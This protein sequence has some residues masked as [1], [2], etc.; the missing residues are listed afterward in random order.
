MFL[1]KFKDQ[2][3]S[4]HLN[5]YQRHEE[6]YRDTFN[7]LCEVLD[8]LELRVEGRTYSERKDS[9]SDLAKRVQQIDSGGLSYNE[10]SLIG[11]F[12]SRHGKRYGL[13]REFRENGI[14]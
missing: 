10:C 4:D 2:N 12:F 13:L 7:P 1:A 9:C 11:E 6:F 3:G 14:L 5:L 8:Y